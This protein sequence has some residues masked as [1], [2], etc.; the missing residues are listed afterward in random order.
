[1]IGRSLLRPEEVNLFSS[2]RFVW[3]AVFSTVFAA[4]ALFA[5]QR[6][7]VTIEAD[8]F[9]RFNLKTIRCKSGSEM[10]LVLK[11][12]GRMPNHAH[13]WVLLKSD[14]DVAAF[15]QAAMGAKATDYVPA[16]QRGAIVA[17]TKL[18]NAGQA[19]EVVFTAPAKGSYPFLCSYPGH[20]SLSR[21]MLVVE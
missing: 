7:T 16:D 5:A 12:V 17:H 3:L 19:V 20:Y 11:N 9:M 6:Q 4:L 1:M 15:G 13:N 10:R 14:A 18:A 21:G 2:A 8:D